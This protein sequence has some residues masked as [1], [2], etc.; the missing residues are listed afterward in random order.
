M[1][2]SK[3]KMAG[4][5][6]FVD[7]TMISF[8]SDLVGVVGPNGCG[9]SNIID[10]VRWVM[11]ESSRHL[12]GDTM[13]DVIFNGSTARKPVSQ[14]SIELV[15]DNSDGSAGGQYAQ[16]S[17]IALRRSVS[18][19]GQSKYFL[20]GSACRRRDVI[21]IFLGTGLGPRS[22][23]IIEQGTISRLIEARPE[24]LRV[25]LEEAAGI[26]KYKERRR[27]TETRMRHARENLNRL[28][29]LLEEV[30]KQ[31]NNLQRQAKTAEKYQRLKQEERK[32]R[33]TLLALRLRRQERDAAT[34][35]QA[36]AEQQIRQE[37]AV[38]ELR[39][40]EAEIEKLRARH[41]RANETFND[42]QGR[43]YK[44][45]GDISR[46][47]QSIQH[48]KALRDRQQ[49]ELDQVREASQAAENELGRDRER[50][51]QLER[52]IA[53]AAPE[54][55][56]GQAE[57]ND[58]SGRLAGAEQSMVQWQAQWE[59]LTLRAA[60]PEQAAQVERARIE[61][62]ERQIVQLDQR[63][64]RLIEEQQLLV[65]C[66]L[67]AEIE[68][69]R[70]QAREIKAQVT[71][72][73][74]QVQAVLASITERREHIK[75]ISHQLDETRKRV[76]HNGGRL[77]S[78]EALQEAA[79]GKHEQAVVHWLGRNGLQDAPRLAEQ[80]VVTAGWERAVETVL[81]PC[82]EAV[83]VGGLE[84]AIE[85]LGDLQQGR[86]HLLDTGASSTVPADEP[87]ADF[88]LS[89]FRAPRALQDLL[90]RVYAAV[91]LPQALQLRARLGAGESV[92]TADG[93][94]IGRDWLRVAREG[95]EHNGVLAREVE[96]KVLREKLASLSRTVED[97][98]AQ[99][100]KSQTL[101]LRLEESREQLQVQTN[102][103]HRVQAEAESRLSRQQHRLEQ[104]AARA[105][106]LALELQ[107][108]QEHL[109]RDREALRL[110]AERRA[111]A[112]DT[113]GMLAREREVLSAQRG[114]LQQTLT[115]A[116][117]Q[118]KQLQEQVHRQ[119]LRLEAMR[120][121]HASIEEGLG[122]MQSQLEQLG[123]RQ[124]ELQTAIAQGLEPLRM[125]E[126]EL[127]DLLQQRLDVERELSAARTDMQD[128]EASLREHD[129]QRLE[130]ER[131][132]D[133]LRGELDSQ[134]MAWQDARVRCQTLKEQFAE[135]GFQLKAI[136]QELDAH[137]AIESGVKPTVE[138]WETQVENL[139][140]RIER[141]GPIN[142]A[143]IDEY[144][145]Q[146]Q[147]KEYLDRQH[148]DLTQ[149]L[150][151]LQ[152]A[153]HKID[154]ETRHRFK[155]TFDRVNARLGEMFPRLFGGGQAHLEMID[156]DLL[157]TGIAIMA[158]P[159]GKRL[160]TIHLMSGGEKALT[161]VALVFA[162]FE[163]NPAPFCLLDEVDAPLDDANVGRF[164]ELVK[165]MSKRVQFIFITHN[166]TTM[167]YAEQLVG[168]T[169]H[170][171]GVSRLVAVDVDEAAKMA[172]G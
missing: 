115:E 116:R 26:S 141:L 7:P 140:E 85:A 128:I 124:T 66:G 143:A 30:N 87:R 48:H 60:G 69:L 64:I 1:R 12:R 93:I 57:L 80:L 68:G 33:A 15:F 129:Q 17:E 56:R 153:I 151:T 38:A 144:R 73:Q 167:E 135:T 18:R 133:T 3:I 49:Q 6:S 102:E 81:G 111:Q 100:A 86:V 2:L 19:D 61:H 51:E 132:L 170:E 46:T 158:R 103:T 148:D 77:S 160:S 166:K 155:E 139:S 110:C 168:V 63:R 108:A 147:R 165:E 59:E 172:T 72:R 125:L 39:S 107:E 54:L 118:A 23:A 32:A 91:D 45:G 164:C 161:A 136:F 53:A 156:N 162:I 74:Q 16:Y 96:I 109:A 67:E 50:L 52:D 41:G 65:Q 146:S 169:M 120:T 99:L 157:T 122:R 14:A 130:I 114:T 150:E 31:I 78:L 34:R 154:R 25:Y 4:F 104:N 58:Q 106:Q 43:Y 84:A 149:A 119:A 98:Q 28:D 37:Q 22:Y 145:E 36:V 97:L 163:L 88:L 121:S 11:G 76:Q 159:P 75:S 134:R 105:A 40:H 138:E 8:P 126:Q 42:V 94:W 9:K 117:T 89:K 10:A 62:L 92:V 47:E 29:D 137:V 82:L 55:E 95:D 27:E 131:R 5:K 127:G 35:G 24:D 70:I 21:D 71:E 90:P 13:E 123:R 171:P 20:N 83:C 79:L 44:S 112:M 152:D 101:L 142:L 113:I